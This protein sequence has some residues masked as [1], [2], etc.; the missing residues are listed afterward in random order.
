M[1]I[2]SFFM[3]VYVS[4][5]IVIVIIITNYYY[6]YF[7]YYVNMYELLCIINV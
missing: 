5:T 6:Y 1:I 4:R 7:Y 2:F 3:Y